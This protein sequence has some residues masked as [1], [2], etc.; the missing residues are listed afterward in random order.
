MEAVFVLSAI[1]LPCVIF[2]IWCLTPP[3]IGLPCVI[4]LIWCLTPPGKKWLKSNHMI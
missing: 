2:L 4:F 1:G 3:G